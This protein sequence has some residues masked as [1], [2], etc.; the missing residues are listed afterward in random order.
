MQS[1]GLS[2]H[3]VSVLMIN[4][5]RP[6]KYA[7]CA[8]QNHDFTYVHFYCDVFTD[9][10]TPWVTWCHNRQDSLYEVRTTVFLACIYI[11]TRSFSEW[12]AS[13]M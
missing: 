8:L 3:V 9:F 12:S 4:G 1:L 13:N 7:V 6:E 5:K 2:E 10:I 11:E